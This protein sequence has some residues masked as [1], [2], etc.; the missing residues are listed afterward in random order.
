MMKTTSLAVLAFLSLMAC[1]RTTEESPAEKA[2]GAERQAKDVER[3]MKTLQTLASLADKVK[4]LDAPTTMKSNV[5]EVKGS[6]SANFEVL[7]AD[8]LS[9]PND[10]PKIRIQS[11]QYFA[12]CAKNVKAKTV[13]M[14]DCIT[15]YVVVL[16]PTTY[17]TAEVSTGSSYTPGKVDAA[18]YVFDMSNGELIGGG[19]VLAKTP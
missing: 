8:E 3:A 18:A 9:S 2:A 13:S 5:L 17:R 12:K 10:Y 15:P 16:K 4:N 11:A 1:K 14:T 7:L 6:G 19:H